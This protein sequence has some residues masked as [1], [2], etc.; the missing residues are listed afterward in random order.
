M[1]QINIINKAFRSHQH[2]ERILHI[3][4]VKTSLFKVSIN[5]WFLEIIL[6]IEQP[7]T[8]VHKTPFTIFQRLL[9]LVENI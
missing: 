8:T 4:H 9:R 2:K 3:H 7:S 6:E 5:Q 1:A